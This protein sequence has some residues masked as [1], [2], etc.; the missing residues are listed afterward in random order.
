[1]IFKAGYFDI[2]SHANNHHLNNECINEKYDFVMTS[3]VW[4]AVRCHLCLIRSILFR[5]NHTLAISG[6]YNVTYAISATSI[7]I[8]DV[9]NGQLPFADGQSSATISL[10]LVDSGFP[11]LDSSFTVTLGLYYIID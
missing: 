7:A 3:H 8:V 5:L 9:L 11:S 2:P 4:Q 1:M 6:S 10:Q